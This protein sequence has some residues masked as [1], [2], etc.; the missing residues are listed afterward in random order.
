MSFITIFLKFLFVVC[1][2][3]ILTVITMAWTKNGLF[4]CPVINTKIEFIWKQN[5]HVKGID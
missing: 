2:A 4:F 3:S 1:P 5:F